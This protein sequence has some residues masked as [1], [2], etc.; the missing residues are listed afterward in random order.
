M[1]STHLV[2]HDPEGRFD[3]ELPLDRELHKCLVKAVLGWTGNPG[4]PPADLQQIALLLTGTARAVAADVRRAADLL[5]EDHA[6]RALADVVLEEADRRLSVPPEGST[7][8]AQNRARLVRALYER[9]DRLV[10]V[11]PQAAAAAS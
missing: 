11:A 5:P 6:A 8:C 3:T 9:L 1:S 2:L 10:A 4:L 7:R